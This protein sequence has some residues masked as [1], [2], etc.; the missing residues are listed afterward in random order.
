MRGHWM[1]DDWG[2]YWQSNKMINEKDTKF[3]EMTLFNFWDAA[4]SFCRDFKVGFLL[5]K[6][7]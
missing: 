5:E 4:V 1:V 7:I 6:T 2:A 3:I